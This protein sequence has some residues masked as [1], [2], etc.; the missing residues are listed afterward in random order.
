MIK[1]D[2]KTSL[3]TIL[4]QKKTTIINIVGLSIGMTAAILILFW[5]QNEK[6]YD[7]YHADADRIYR[8]T[9]H[10]TVSSGDTWVWENSPLIYADAAK[11]EIPEIENTARLYSAAWNPLIINRNGT[12]MKEH[13]GAYVDSNWFS[14]FSY[15]VLSGSLASF[16]RHPNNIILTESRAKKLFGNSD[17][18]GK[19]L[20]SDTMS[21]T[22]QAV[23]AD[24]PT[25][26]SFQFDIFIP[27]EARL[28]DKDTRNDENDWG[29]FNYLTFVKLRPTAKSK[30]TEAKLTALIRKSKLE[31]D[32]KSSLTALPD[33]HF[34]TGLQSSAT[35]H[36]NENTIHVFSLLGILLL[37]MACINYVNLTTAR[38]SLR[39]KEVSIRKIVGAGRK[40]LFLQF[41]TE[42]FLMSLL[43]VVLTLVLL[44]L[45]LPMFNKITDNHFILALNDILLWKLIGLAILATTVLNGIYPA[46]LLS[47]FNPLHVFRGIGLL[48]IRDAYFRKTLVVVQFSIAVG[49]IIGTIV[50]FNQMQYIQ[51]S[52][53]GYNKSQIV[54]VIVPWKAFGGY[55]AAEKQKSGMNSIVQQ[56]KAESSIAEVSVAQDN[57]VNNLSLS[58]GG[59]DWDGRPEDFKPSITRFSADTNFRKMFNIQLAEGEW[60]TEDLSS[61][62]KFLLNETAVKEL[63]IRK[64]ALGQR[65]VV[66]KD[67]GIISGVIKD[68][69]FKSMHDKI[70]PLVM[71]NDPWRF[72]LFIQVQPGQNAKAL[73]AIEKIW[74]ANLSK[75][76]FE[77]WFL[78]EMFNSVY[79]TD[80][81]I[82][83]LVLIFCGIA[84]FISALGLFG[85]TAFTAERKTREI[86]IRKV[87]GASVFNIVTLLSREFI[88]L[89]TLSILIAIPLALMMMNSWLNNFAYRINIGIW[90]FAL[91]A[92]LALLIALATIS[93]QAV[94]AALANPVKNLRTE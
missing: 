40:E 80:N 15:K 50:I 16:N 7:R 20:L 23:V 64:P 37:L 69:H 90:I 41:I 30:Q 82:S 49:L 94:K 63:N 47:S 86:G 22:V 91:A 75:F 19:S 32:I 73:A 18:V 57:M 26:S 44:R 13:G 6:S 43:S 70:S 52:N 92:A 39:A 27:I 74:K 14:M 51:R 1:T 5:V 58:S 9:N 79:A 87:L 68:F 54:N 77:Y 34:E 25:N 28:A 10:L 4:K 36:I 21:Y 83:T 17:A 29:N 76:P 71:Y 93:L 42:S 78:D 35:R 2:I 65:F 53:S 62:K 72:Q 56:L 66:G 89:V 81:R 46:L 31:S 60:Y 88:L 45:S 67:T 84:L 48:R 24:N 11:R 85:L 12:L 55:E 33:M 61:V 8:I 3:R 59:F 38:A